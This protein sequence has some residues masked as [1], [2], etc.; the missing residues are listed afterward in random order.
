MTKKRTFLR[1]INSLIK[2]IGSVTADQVSILMDTLEG[3]DAERGYQGS[4]T[5]EVAPSSGAYK[6]GKFKFE[7]YIVNDYPE[8]PPEVRCLTEIY[9]PNI[10][11]DDTDSEGSN[12]CVSLLEQGEWDSNMT[13]E[14]CVQAILFLFFN[15]NWNDA[16]SPLFSPDLTDSEFEENVKISIEGG[17]IE[18]K[19]FERNY[20]LPEVDKIINDA[21]ESKLTD[22]EI[23]LN[24]INTA[25]NN[26]TIGN[27]HTSPTENLGVEQDLE[28]TQNENVFSTCDAAQ[29]NIEIPT[30]DLSAQEVDSTTQEVDLSTQEV[31]QQEVEQETNLDVAHG[32][33]VQ[34]EPQVEDAHEG[35]TNLGEIINI[36]GEINTDKGETT[37]SE[38]VENILCAMILDNSAVQSMKV[39]KHSGFLH[40]SLSVGDTP[41][42]ETIKLDRNVIVNLNKETVNRLEMQTNTVCMNVCDSSIINTERVDEAGCSFSLVVNEQQQLLPDDLENTQNLKDQGVFSL[43]RCCGNRVFSCNVL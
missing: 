26:A 31:I 18:G 5:A 43:D 34:H 30:A 35:K 28:E 33:F 22:Q 36:D 6:G 29:V 41:R 2:T 37:K 39:D 15:P 20:G 19:D 14:H 11:T 12:I 10:D 42:G 7:I 23:E 17:C 13:L 3:E 1:D 8:Y 16:L 40:R 24:N 27:V 25:L 32:E 4:V 38:A 9:H 21:D